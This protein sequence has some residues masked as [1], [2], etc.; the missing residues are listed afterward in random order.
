[1]ATIKPSESEGSGLELR[2]SYKRFVLEGVGLKVDIW[3]SLNAQ[4]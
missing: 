2:E 1:M 4:I 3:S